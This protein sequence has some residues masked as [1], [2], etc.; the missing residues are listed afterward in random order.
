MDTTSARDDPTRTALKRQY[1]A[2]LAMLRTAVERFPDDRW[3]DAVADNAFWQIAYH[4]IFYTH[5][6]LHLGIDAFRSFPGHRGDVQNVGSLTGPA[7]PDSTLDL[8][9]DPYPK[10]HVLA[11][12]DHLIATLDASVDDLD[13]TAVESGFPWYAMPKLEHQLVNLRHLQHH[14][15]QLV[16]RLRMATGSGV[17]WV[18]SG[19]QRPSRSGG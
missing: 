12:A 18:G 6:Y 8:L 1:H 2:G 14:T 17:G 11:Y 15:G 10:A 5:L 4:T 13:L 3:T 19:S 7:D 9:P 16:E